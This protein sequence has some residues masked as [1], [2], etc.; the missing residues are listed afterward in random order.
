MI[1]HKLAAEAVVEDA[2][3]EGAVAV[4]AEAVGIVTETVIFEFSSND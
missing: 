1:A 3:A 4:D 2:A